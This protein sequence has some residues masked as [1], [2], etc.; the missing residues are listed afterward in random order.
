MAQVDACLAATGQ[1]SAQGYASLPAVEHAPTFD[2][3]T[4]RCP[5]RVQRSHG[6]KLL[7]KSLTWA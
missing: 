6:Q 2:R 4:V 7:I 5:K 1:E 3:Y